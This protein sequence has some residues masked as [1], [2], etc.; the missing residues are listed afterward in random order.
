MRQQNDI[1]CAGQPTESFIK[2]ILGKCYCLWRMWRLYGRHLQICTYKE[3]IIRTHT[4]INVAMWL[5]SWFGV[6]Y[7]AA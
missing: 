2:I 1:C 5:P 6:L 3:N 4:Y 7:T